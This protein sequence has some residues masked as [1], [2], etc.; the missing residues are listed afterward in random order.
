MRSAVT[1]NQTQQR[2]LPQKKLFCTQQTAFIV[3]LHA[4]ERPS[5]TSADT[6]LI[7]LKL[8]HTSLATNQQAHN[9]TNQY[10]TLKLL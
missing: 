4:A 3:Y 5:S 6:G 8:K 10:L 2:A 7:L 1:M 9:T